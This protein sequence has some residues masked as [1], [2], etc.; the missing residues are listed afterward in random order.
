M[1]VSLVEA[2][3]WLAFALWWLLGLFLIVYMVLLARRAVRAL[4]RIATYLEGRIP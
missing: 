3:P 1:G 2:G 4:E